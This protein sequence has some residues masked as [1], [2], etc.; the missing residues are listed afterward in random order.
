MFP[1]LSMDHPHLQNLIAKRVPEAARENFMKKVHKLMNEE[2]SGVQS[3]AKVIIA[4]KKKV[5]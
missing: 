5:E 3:W 1:F 2:K 4:R